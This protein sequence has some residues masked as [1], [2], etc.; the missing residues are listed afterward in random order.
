MSIENLKYV[1]I[2]PIEVQKLLNKKYKIYF[3][4]MGY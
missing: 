4:F 1:E 2:L 3:Q